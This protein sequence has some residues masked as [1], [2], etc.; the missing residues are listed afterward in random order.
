MSS[1]RFSYPDA[2]TSVYSSD[3]IHFR[4][5]R[6]NITL[7]SHIPLQDDP[8][9]ESSRI[10]E[11]LLQFLYNQPQ[12]DLAELYISCS[13]PACRGGPQVSSL[14]CQQL[15]QERALLFDTC[16]LASNPQRRAQMKRPFTRGRCS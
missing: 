3:G 1:S 4:L 7:N 14:R 6:I 10:L 11:L 2:D 16:S 8:L 13:S 12:P 5:H 15:L 9:P